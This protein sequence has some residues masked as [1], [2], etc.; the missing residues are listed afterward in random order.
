MYRPVKV[1][2]PEG[3]L[4]NPRFPA[5]VV[6]RAITGH[7]VPVLVF[8]ALHQVIPDRVMAGAGSP[9]WARHAV[10]RARRRQALHHR[11]LLQ[12]RHGRDVGQ[13]RRAR[14]VLAEQHLLDARRGGRAP[15]PALLPLQAPA[16]GLGRRRPLP[17]R[18]RPGHPHR[19]RVGAA[20]HRELHGRAHALP[21][22]RPRGRRRRRHRRRAASTAARSTIADSTSLPTAIRCSS[23]RRA[24]GGYGPAAE[25]DPKLAERDRALGYTSRSGAKKA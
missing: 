2:A 19:E 24:A 5:A 21:R 17:R 4:L 9:L 6:S 8:G 12:R 18:P 16:P 25:R 20:D 3:C 7:Y 22:P 15:E 14:A 1:Q 23:A 13:G 10:G 11:A